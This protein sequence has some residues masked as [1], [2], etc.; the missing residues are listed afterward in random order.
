MPQTPSIGF[1]RRG[2]TDLSTDRLPNGIVHVAALGSDVI[3]LIQTA[4][5]TVTNASLAGNAKGTSDASYFAWDG[6]F[7]RVGFQKATGYVGALAY[8]SNAIGAETTTLDFVQMVGASTIDPA[9]GGARTLRGQFDNTG[10]FRVFQQLYVS[11]PATMLSSMTVT[12][13][14]TASSTLH[15][16]DTL[17]AD[18][19]VNANSLQV[20]GTATV[21]GSNIIK[22]SDAASTAPPAIGSG[23]SV[24]GAINTRFAREDH[25]HGLALTGPL[26]LGGVSGTSASTGGSIGDK[27]SLFSTSYGFGIQASRL[28]AYMDPSA[29]FAIRSYS[30]TG[31][32]SSGPDGITLAASGAI[33]GATTIAA[34]GTVTGS[35]FIIPGGSTFG[36]TVARG[37]YDDSVNVAVRAPA[38]TGGVYLQNNGGSSTYAMYSAASAF[39][40]GVATYTVTSPLQTYNASTLFRIL[41]KTDIQNSSGTSYFTFDPTITN[42]DGFSGAI[43]LPQGSLNG[44]SLLTGSVPF[45]K[46]SPA[47][48]AVITV[49]NPDTTFGFLRS[50]TPATQDASGFSVG[51]LV[52]GASASRVTDGL[53]YD[54]YA[55][56]AT[57][58]TTTD[59]SVMSNG[60]FYGNISNS[61]VADNMYPNQGFGLKPGNYRA[62]IY[63][64]VSNAS[65]TLPCATAFVFD[66]NAATLAGGTQTKAITPAMLGSTNYVA[67]T[68]PFTVAAWSRSTGASFGIQVGLLYGAS[69][70]VDVYVSHVV[71]SPYTIGQAELTTTFFADAAITNAKI[72]DLSVNKL[73]S[74]VIQSDDINIGSGGR[75]YIGASKSATTRMEWTA[76]GFFSY[77][78]GV[79]TVG[80]KNDGTFKLLSASSGSRINVDSTIGME[81]YDSTGARTLYAAI[82]GSLTVKGA[83]TATSLDVTGATITGDAT[84]GGSLTVGN[85]GTP[86]YVQLNSAGYL[87][88]KKGVVEVLLDARSSGPGLGYSGYVFALNVNG[89]PVFS[90]DTNGSVK[91]QDINLAGTATVNGTLTL[92]TGTITAPHFNVTAAGLLTA[93]GAYITGTINADTLNLSAGAVIGGNAYVSGTLTGGTFRGGTIISPDITQS[94]YTLLNGTQFSLTQ[95]ATTNLFRDPRFNQGGAS[96]SGNSS[97][98]WSFQGSAVSDYRN[99]LDFVGLYD[100]TSL[101]VWNTSSPTGSVDVRCCNLSPSTTYTLSFHASTSTINNTAPNI[102]NNVSANHGQVLVWEDGGLQRTISQ[103]T[104]G[105]VVFGGG[106]Y[107]GFRLAG[108]TGI[109]TM[110]YLGWQ[111]RYYKTFTTPSDLV[112][113]GAVVVRLPAP[114]TSTG[115]I[116]TTMAVC[117]DGLQIE[118]GSFMTKYTDGDQP[119]SVWNGTA[120]ASTSSR[121]NRPS[122]LFMHDMDYEVS[123]TVNT[124]RVQTRKIKIGTG[125]VRGSNY[126]QATAGT[127]LGINRNTWTNAN[128]TVVGSDRNAADDGSVFSSFQYFTAPVSA[129]YALSAT[130][131]WPADSTGERYSQWITT[132]GTILART[133]M[134][135]I[136]DVGTSGSPPNTGQIYTVSCMTYLPA[137]TICLVQHYHTSTTSILT[138][139]THTAATPNTANFALV[140]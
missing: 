7:T 110:G 34:S 38:G 6:N 99:N 68:V 40:G 33:A 13:A 84:V 17:L 54:G 2:T 86:S 22:V 82:G 135:A 81:F 36:G 25:S 15:V 124:S 107:S 79:Q 125:P 63:M 123:A 49:T 80:I 29:A 90:L 55:I 59:G 73:T 14:I 37:F 129:M 132:G 130:V 48:Q 44:S 112:S 26:D 27:I 140:A 64:R 35:Q 117:Y 45:S 108:S 106:Q 102:F 89:S 122:L 139:G 43:T 115:G 111:T 85:L 77:I 16:T 47:A 62:Q 88:A 120:N 105:V 71:V 41:G 126:L 97:T 56:K 21:G 65:S 109:T 119:S 100:S 127:T 52:V 3:T 114:S 51:N 67:V 76:A 42:A 20:V 70:G 103:G 131:T 92:G 32:K 96:F 12:G 75:I 39:V 50:A 116:E 30:N 5:T 10:N 31:N 23:S 101:K 28:V 58:G 78:N 69:A 4:T 11:G 94:G 24:L 121:V 104:D 18:G 74:G 66:N 46:L 1:G 9:G 91:A 61:S 137:G 8:V 128:Y 53:A 19:L 93:S 138:L 72:N 87:Q 113:G 60:P 95:V 118:Q 83:L 136:Q 98:N 134:S 133:N 57:Y